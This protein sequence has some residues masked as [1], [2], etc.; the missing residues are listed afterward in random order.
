MYAPLRSTLTAGVALVGA[1]AIAVSPLMMPPQA[2]DVAVPR[3]SSAA[4]QLNAA[5]D[6]NAAW[7][8]AFNTA[9]ANATKVS[10][11]Y[12][13]APN[14]ALQQAIVNLVGYLDDDPAT[15]P[16][17]I[18]DNLQAALRAATFLGY[19][20]GIV[21]T[22]F[23]R[24]SGINSNHALFQVLTQGFLT[25][26]APDEPIP[27]LIK[28]LSSPLSG[29]L[30]GT[31]GPLIAPGVA[32]YNSILEIVDALSAETPD[33]TAATQALIDMP[34]SVIGAFFNGATLDLTPLIPAIK[35]ANI[36]PLPDG[37]E[38]L[39]LSFA[40]GGL[41]SP[42]LTGQAT[43]GIGGSIFNALG[44]KLKIADPFPLTLNI[45]GQ[46]VGPIAAWTNLSQVVARSIGWDGVGNPLT[47]LTFPVIKPAAAPA[48]KS[49][50]AA[51]SAPA[52]ESATDAAVGL[53][54]SD[55]AAGTADADE[56]DKTGA[57]DVTQAVDT[58]SGTSEVRNSLRAVPGSHPVN[59]V[60]HRFA[61]AVR[62]IDDSINDSLNELSDGVRK[63]ANGLTGNSRSKD[64][65]AGAEGA[66]GSGAGGGSG[67][68][69]AEG[70]NGSGASGSGSG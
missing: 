20:P 50:T 27:T 66:S 57:G 10:N 37:A 63:L 9:S 44:M 28:F 11:A 6:P 34:A 51:R 35:E 18:M 3:V 14:A 49:L 59:R 17:Q 8:G 26:P 31:V 15:V 36:L 29:A 64:S 22:P 32:L 46:G 45:V 21:P 39:A 7:V 70:A 47:D 55:N 67:N 41:L 24:F 13:Q 33:T 19:E 52:D 43:P 61:T 1:S 58:R 42:G 2:S 54:A 68:A 62:A 25:I 48:Q 40:F 30:I 38:L 4:V 12:F 60:E 65:N 69:G 56:V 16:T 23:P 5:I 53:G